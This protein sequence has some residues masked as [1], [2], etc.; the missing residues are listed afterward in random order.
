MLA[1]SITIATASGVRCGDGLDD[2]THVYDIYSSVLTP[3]HIV[4]VAVLEGAS[5]AIILPADEAH[6]G[7]PAMTIDET[8]AGLVRLFAVPPTANEPLQVIATDPSR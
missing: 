7:D 8:P 6:H 3:G 4:I 5:A 1:N 2:G